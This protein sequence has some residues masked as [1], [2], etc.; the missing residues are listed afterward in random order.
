MERAGRSILMERP[1]HLKNRQK[2]EIPLN[3]ALREA[4]MKWGSRREK[5]VARELLKKLSLILLKRKNWHKSRE[6]TTCIWPDDRGTQ[7]Q[8]D[9]NG[10]ILNTSFSNVGKW[11]K[12][13]V[14]L[15]DHRYK[16]VQ[17]TSCGYFWNNWLFILY[18]F[19]QWILWL[20]K[21]F[22]KKFLAECYVLPR[23]GI[24]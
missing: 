14:H 10:L 2:V 23:V 8:E 11:W 6:F 17:D 7:N 21:I 1:F 15:V 22:P 5:Y 13:T 16:K 19:L 18:R 20:H 4:I 24:N 3:P 12:A 9:K